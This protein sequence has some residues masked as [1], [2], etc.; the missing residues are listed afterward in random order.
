MKVSLSRTFMWI[1]VLCVRPRTTPACG[2][3]VHAKW[4]Y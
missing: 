1:S 3:G 2:G 4:Y